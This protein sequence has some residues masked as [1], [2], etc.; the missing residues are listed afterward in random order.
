MLTEPEPALR[1]SRLDTIPGW[2]LLAGALGI[3][4]VFL[5]R[6]GADTHIFSADEDQYAYFSRWFP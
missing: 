2:A 6:R 1:P 5:A 3:A 4:F